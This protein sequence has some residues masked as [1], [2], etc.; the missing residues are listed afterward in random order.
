MTRIV[1]AA[2]LAMTIAGTAGSIFAAN[3]DG[4]ELTNFKQLCV[5]DQRTGL[6]WKNGGWHHANH[7][8]RKYV[9]KK[10][11]DDVISKLFCSK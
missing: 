10:L 8:L 5:D 3:K 2:L 11:P 9:I 1:I 7:K 4:E 6:N